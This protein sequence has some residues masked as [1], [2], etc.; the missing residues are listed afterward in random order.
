VEG[1]DPDTLQGLRPGGQGEEV[2]R[3]FSIVVALTG[4]YVPWKF[5]RL[6]STLGTD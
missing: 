3:R 6:A 1:E 2:C 5:R 4:R